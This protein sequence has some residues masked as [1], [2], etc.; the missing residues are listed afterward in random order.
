VAVHATRSEKGTHANL[1]ISLRRGVCNL[2]EGERLSAILW[3]FSPH[4][5]AAGVVLALR[6]HLT[7]KERKLAAVNNKLP[8]AGFTGLDRLPSPEAGFTETM[9][10]MRDNLRSL[11]E[12]DLAKPD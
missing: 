11:R 3:V 8:L 1:K 5:E 4:F 2:I 6:A 10:L 9:L 7:S 12:I